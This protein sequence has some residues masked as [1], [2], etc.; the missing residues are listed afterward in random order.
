MKFNINKI[1]IAG[2]LIGLTTLTAFAGFYYDSFRVT[3][4]SDAYG[5]R[6]LRLPTDRPIR[7]V[8]KLSKA[9][10]QYGVSWGITDRGIWVDRGCRAIFE[11]AGHRP[12]RWEVVWETTHY[13]D[14]NYHH[15]RRWEDRD[16]DRWH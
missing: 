15:F 12:D 2:G 16:W 13:R 5:W 8:K 6:L 10:C 1:V 11:V 3:V 7:L 14:D 9:G 4:D